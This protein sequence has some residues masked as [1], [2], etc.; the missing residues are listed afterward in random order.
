MEIKNLESLPI[1][2]RDRSAINSYM[3]QM[4]RILGD[5]LLSITIYGSAV[6]DNYFP[7]SSD[8]NLLVLVPEYSPGILKK[9]SPVAKGFSGRSRISSFVVDVNDIKDSA[10]VFPVKYL[11]M[12]NHHVVLCG[13]DIFDDMEIDKTNIRFDLERQ[14]RKV[15]LRLREMYMYS[16][17]TVAE[18]RNILVSNFSGFALYMAALL[19]L[20]NIK[21]PVKKEDIIKAASLEFSLDLSVLE[22]VLNLKKGGNNPPR[23]RMQKLF[24]EYFVVVDRIVEIVDKMEVK[25]A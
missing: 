24:D 23:A 15:S 11:D 14:I 6:K 2:D 3:K 20:H 9:V 5:Q 17:Y 8:L 10:D 21:A 19:H 18:L 7:G 22:S 13:Q 16:N 25:S 12:K 1:R 4:N